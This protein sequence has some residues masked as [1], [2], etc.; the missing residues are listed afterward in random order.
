MDG[1]G[2]RPLRWLSVLVV[3]VVIHRPLSLSTRARMAAR[4]RRWYAPLFWE[5]STFS[6]F[7]LKW[8]WTIPFECTFL[9]QAKLIE[10]DP[11]RCTDVQLPDGAVFVVS[12]C[13]LELNKA[14]TSQYNTRVAECR[15]GAQ[16]VKCLVSLLAATW[17]RVLFPFMWSSW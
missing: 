7:V 9:F 8:R 16:V 15:L 11:I 3:V 14:A 4:P 12:N 1:W 17:W 13:L 5:A 2:A 10:F 6:L